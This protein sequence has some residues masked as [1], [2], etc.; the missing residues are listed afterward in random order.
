MA[1]SK[2]RENRLHDAA[3]LG[4]RLAIGSVFIFHSLGKFDPGFAGFLNQLG[5][6]VEMQILIALAELLS[7][8]FL[9]FGI[10][11]RI[12]ASI[13]SMIALGVIFHVKHAAHLT[14][15]G[16]FELELVLLAGVLTTIVAGPGRISISHIIKKVPRFLQ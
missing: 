3:H 2:F 9:I 12:A 8:I 5:I 16:G 10:L 13:L 1:D 4:V 6:P 15:Q 7:G 11:A 14:G